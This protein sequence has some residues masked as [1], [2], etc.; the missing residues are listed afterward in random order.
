AVH[1]TTVRAVEDWLA[2]IEREA[3]TWA[4][5]SMVRALLAGPPARGPEVDTPELLSLLRSAESLVGYLVIDPAGHVVA[6]DDVELR[7]QTLGHGLPERIIADLRRS[8]NQSTVVLPAQTS[9]GLTERGRVPG[10]DHEFGREVLSAA[11]VPD[12]SR[13]IAGVLLLRFDPQ[14]DLGRILRQ[15]R[16]GESGDTYAFTRSGRI[17]A[18]GAPGDQLRG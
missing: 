6:S 3:S 15:G 16:F 17:L 5:S 2:G 10:G 12:R 18:D 7:G 11:G 9:I 8:P 13:A 14:L 4:R 1:R